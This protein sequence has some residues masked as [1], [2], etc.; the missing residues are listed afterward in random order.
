[1]IK[2]RRIRW[3]GNAARMREM[4]NAY[5]ILFGKPEGR[6][7]GRPRRTWEDDIRMDL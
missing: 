1:M 4:R 7:L 6:A 5:K 3:T 2:S